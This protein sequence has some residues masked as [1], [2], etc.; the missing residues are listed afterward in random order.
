MTIL[1][2]EDDDGI[3]DSLYCYL[4]IANA[5]VITC[6][7]GKHAVDYLMV[8]PQPTL[9]ILDLAMPK[10]NGW[11]FRSWQKRHPTLS[12]VPVI[13]Y[14]AFHWTQEQQDQLQAAAYMSKPFNLVDMKETIEK[15]IA[16]I[17]P[18]EDATKPNLL[19][20]RD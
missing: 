4:E 18:N 9:I 8:H 5:T 11:E 10:M 15:V 14:T 16:E 1:V 7:D 6:A 3:R 12:K 13:V 2:I 20:I 19:P 17:P